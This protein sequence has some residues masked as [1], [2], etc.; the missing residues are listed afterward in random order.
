MPVERAP[1][2][3]P[4]GTALNH[5]QIVVRFD[6]LLRRMG[7]IDDNLR[8][9]YVAHAMGVAS[10]WKQKCW[11]YN[12]WAVKRD[13]GIPTEY[14]S[15]D[16]YLM[17]TTEEVKGQDVKVPRAQWR[18]FDSWYQALKDTQ[19]RIGPA[20]WNPHYTAAYE[21]ALKGDC[22]GYW[23]ELGLGGYYSETHWMQPDDFIS[24][25]NRVEKE[26]RAAS[27]ADKA[28]A[29]KW[30]EA[31]WAAGLCGPLTPVFPGPVDPADKKTGYV[32]AGVLA[33]LAA[34]VLAFK[35]IFRK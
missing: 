32:I 31:Q 21:A 14:W 30:V 22:K 18:A 19:N 26:L 24:V 7:V 35:T 23:A 28:D 16:W 13:K 4:V 25:C 11:W 12:A 27:D 8:K 2:H 1:R 17:A 15:G 3:T 10:G 20:S 29:D 33:A 6:A 5:R 9:A 34:A